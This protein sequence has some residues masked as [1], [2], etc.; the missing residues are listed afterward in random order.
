LHPY[1][2]ETT[3]DY[4]GPPPPFR[5]TRRSGTYSWVKAPR[6]R[7][8]PMEMGP[9]ARIVLLHAAAMRPPRR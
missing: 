7:G 5:T 3:L 2:G 8:K 4:T 9:L 1:D 6:W